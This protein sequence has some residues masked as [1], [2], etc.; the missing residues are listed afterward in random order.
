[1]IYS[2]AAQDELPA[3][4]TLKSL[5][6]AIFGA[7]GGGVIRQE[8][9]DRVRGREVTLAARTS[10]LERELQDLAGYQITRQKCGICHSA[11]YINLQPSG[12]TTQQ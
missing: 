5:L 6:T 10:S 11:D 4:A 7:H 8:A 9:A 1:M 2:I 12:M 3:Y